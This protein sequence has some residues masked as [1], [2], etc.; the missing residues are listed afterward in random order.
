MTKCRH[1]IYAREV[2]SDTH[3]NLE[4]GERFDAR[5]GRS[6]ALSCFGGAKVSHRLCLASLG[7]DRLELTLQFHQKFIEKK[8]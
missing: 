1:E 6:K 5:E 4:A 2:V 3:E 7:F 8:V